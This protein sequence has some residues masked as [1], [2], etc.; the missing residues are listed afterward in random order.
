MSTPGAMHGEMPGNLPGRPG[1]EHEPLLDMIFERRPIPP[2]APRE[3]HDLAH[4][5]A[6]AAGSAESGELAG[7]AA[8][9]AAFTRQ[10]SSPGTSPAAR[11]PAWGWLS[12]RPPRGK[13]PLAAAL[14]VAA[15]GLGST[16]AAYADVLP[17]PIQH[18]AHRMVGAP[19]GPG[20]QP[21]QPLSLPRLSPHA[22]LSTSPGPEPNWAAT[23]LS[24]GNASAAVPQGGPLG[25][26]AK[27]A[28]GVCAPR[29]PVMKGVPRRHRPRSCWRRGPDHLPGR[30]SR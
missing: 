11:R 4:M 15:T 27:S 7:E 29:L 17:A 13:L 5:L 2:G 12:G 28:D 1:G 30:H 20:T 9:L 25:D 14:V 19:N 21:T 23:T 18:F 6:A 10:F 22:Q 3:I 8:A 26:R 24:H 16:A